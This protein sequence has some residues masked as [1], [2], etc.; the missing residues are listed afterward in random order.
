MDRQVGTSAR[1]RSGGVLA[2]AALWVHRPSSVPRQLSWQGAFH[3]PAR[4]RKTLRARG[5]FDAVVEQS[6]SGESAQLSLL[7]THTGFLEAF[8]IVAVA[9]AI[10]GLFFF[11]ARGEYGIQSY[12]LPLF[13]GL[14]LFFLLVFP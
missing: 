9:V 4:V 14:L 3:H 11:I 12:V 6:I 2:A 7:G 5:R 13:T 1:D 10:V 8:G